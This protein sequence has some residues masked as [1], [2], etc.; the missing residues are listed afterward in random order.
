MDSEHPNRKGHERLLGLSLVVIF[1]LLVAATVGTYLAGIAALHGRLRF[2]VP[3]VLGSVRM[4]GLRPSE[5]VV[6]AAILLMT[7]AFL[8]LLIHDA[9]EPQA[10]D[11]TAD[12]TA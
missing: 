8:G 1:A 7:V 5:L 10:A 2:F 12:R 4:P 3:A 11:D 9:R 6:A